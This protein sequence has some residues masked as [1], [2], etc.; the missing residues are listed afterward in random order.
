[1]ST[2]T[3]I[4]RFN[5][6]FNEYYPRMLR[7]ALGYVKDEQVAEDIVS[8]SFTRYWE[9]MEKLLPDTIPQ[10]YILTIVRNKCL[11]YL[12]HVQ[13]RQRAEKQL[14]EHAEWALKTRIQ[15]LEACDPDFL[16]SK[17]IRELILFS[18]KHL[19]EKT[20]RIFLLNRYKGLSYKE[21]AQ[22]LD[23]SPKTVEFHISKALKLLRPLLKDFISLPFFLLL[24]DDLFRLLF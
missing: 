8:E 14:N 11:N 23:I 3:S 2:F 10:A 20:R 21:I 16:F 18:L 7:F 24:D 19:P 5:R 15:T 9:E 17:E 22:M 12:E 1:M 4:Q 6:L 13:V